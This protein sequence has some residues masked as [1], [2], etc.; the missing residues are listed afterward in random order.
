MRNID[1]GQTVASSFQTPVL[2]SIAEDLRQMELQ[3][4]VDEADVGQV[5]PG[6]KA[7]FTVDAFPDR[8]F[9]ASIRD[10]RY[11][12]ETIQGVV[13]YKALL[14]IDNTELLLRPGMT[15]T[16]EI[17]VIDIA[18]TVLIPNAALRYSPP[19]TNAPKVSFLRR[20]LPGPP[21]F[22]PASTIGESGPNRTVWSAREWRSAIREGR[23]RSERRHAHPDAG[24]PAEAGPGSHHRPDRR[25][26]TGCA[27]MNGNPIIEFKG[28]WKTF[29]T[30]VAAV[31]ALAGVDLAIAEGEFVAIMGPSGSG[32]STAMNI[33]GC[34]DTPTRGHHFFQ[35]VEV[36]S[37]G[38]NERALVRRHL[39]G[40]VFQGFNLL[41]RTTALE[42]VELPLIYRGM[43]TAERRELA[44][45]ALRRVGLVGPRKPYGSRVVRRPAATRRHRAGDR[46]QPGGAPGGRAD[47]QSRHPHKPRNHGVDDRSQSASA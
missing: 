26:V 37:L 39:L 14:E 41:P 24:R 13:T 9:P 38:R 16:A 45:D 5:Q 28:V 1:P 4:D 11:A 43:G 44:A 17:E 7:A 35:G 2:F 42:N 36:G 25:R 40:F 10:I 34:L 33:I 21:Q 46:D 6:Q 3:V 32:K 27:A 23:D 8:S 15:A 19:D 30:G 47:R 31:N 22:R 29:G 18:Q 12:A 20:M